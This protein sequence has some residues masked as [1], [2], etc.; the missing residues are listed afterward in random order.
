MRN[1]VF[2]TG[3]GLVNDITPLVIMLVGRVRGG[4]HAQQHHRQRGK[5][6]QPSQ[7]LVHRFFP[8]IVRAMARISAA[9]PWGSGACFLGQFMR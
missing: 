3:G 7:C 4:Q 9:L 8:F 1:P 5:R 6:K 2:C